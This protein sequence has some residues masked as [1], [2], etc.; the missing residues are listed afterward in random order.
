MLKD[1]A[2][3]LFLYLA[4]I[5]SFVGPLLVTLSYVSPMAKI[6]NW[7]PLVVIKPSSSTLY[8]SGDVDGPSVFIGLLSRSIGLQALVI[9]IPHFRVL[10]TSR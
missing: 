10:F 4:P 6:G 3:A 8:P 9:L 2:D 1:L 5:L 7:P